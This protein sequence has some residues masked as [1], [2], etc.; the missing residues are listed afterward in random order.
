MHRGRSRKQHLQ[1]VKSCLKAQKCKREKT[2]ALDYKEG[3]SQSE[4]KPGG[5]ERFGVCVA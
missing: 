4:L 1:I 5:Q 2:T 3:H